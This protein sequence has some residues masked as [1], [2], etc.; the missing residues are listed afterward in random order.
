MSRRRRRERGFTLIEALVALGVLA[1]TI[2][3]VTRTFAGGWYAVRQGGLETRAVAVAKAQLDA[4]GLE[5]PLA[6]GTRSGAEGDVRWQ[7]QVSPYATPDQPTARP[8]LPAWWVRV[9]VTWPHGAFGADRTLTLTTVK[10]G[11]RAP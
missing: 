2:A 7:I 1:A 6:A 3:L 10:L 4:V 9:D 11:G 5:V 8:R